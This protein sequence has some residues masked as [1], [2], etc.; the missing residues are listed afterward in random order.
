MAGNTYLSITLNVNQRD[1]QLN[2]IEQLNGLKQNK[3][4]AA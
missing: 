2:D 3:I 4:N 1:V